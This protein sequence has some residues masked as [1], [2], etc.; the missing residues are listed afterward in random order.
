MTIFGP[1]SLSVEKCT[2]SPNVVPGTRLNELQKRRR[3]CAVSGV[4]ANH[5]VLPLRCILATGT[6]QTRETPRRRR[7]GYMP[8]T[9]R[10]CTHFLN[11]VN[12]FNNGPL[13]DQEAI[14]EP[15]PGFHWSLVENAARRVPFENQLNGDSR[16]L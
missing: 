13:R 14:R 4:A 16:R 15:P 5:D 3:T 10:T 7:I 2:A 11:Y 8:D 12:A 1:F 6:R 9:K